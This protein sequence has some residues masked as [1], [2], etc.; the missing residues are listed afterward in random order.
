MPAGCGAD[1]SSSGLGA[2][3][4]AMPGA[5]DLLRS[6]RDAPADPQAA[7]VAAT[8]PA[9][10]YGTSLAWPAADLTRVVGA[11]VVI[12]DGEMTVYLARGLPRNHRAICR[13]TNRFA[14]VWR[15]LPLAR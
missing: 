1:I 10:P 6:M 8:D 15:G 5:L 7:V 11:T 9:N 2:T 14:R 12:V 13:R 4:F 3:Q